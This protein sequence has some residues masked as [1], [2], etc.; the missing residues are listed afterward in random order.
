MNR[1]TQ[2][3]EK[4][5]SEKTIHEEWIAHLSVDERIQT[6]DSFA[7]SMIRGSIFRN[8]EQSNFIGFIFLRTIKNRR[9]KKYL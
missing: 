9:R 6:Q 2:W 5:R 7:T 4:E 1:N 3:Q 8:H